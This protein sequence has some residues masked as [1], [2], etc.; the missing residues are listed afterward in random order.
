MVLFLM[1]FS[2]HMSM[3]RLTEGDYVR[4]QEDPGK[5]LVDLFK[6]ADS[7]KILNCMI[8]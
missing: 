5:N 4:G 2:R 6:I 3:N 1:Y 7:C 8:L